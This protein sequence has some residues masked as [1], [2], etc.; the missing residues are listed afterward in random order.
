V[1]AG[2]TTDDEQLA[3]QLAIGGDGREAEHDGGGDPPPADRIQLA[4]RLPPRSQ[5]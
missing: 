1:P 4:G 2:G 3:M 5:E